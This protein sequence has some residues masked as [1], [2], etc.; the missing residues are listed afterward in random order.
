MQPF[1][2]VLIV[3]KTKAWNDQHDRRLYKVIK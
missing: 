1:K 3:P 2:E